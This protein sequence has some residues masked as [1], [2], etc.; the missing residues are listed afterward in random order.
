MHR[1]TRAI[2]QIVF[3]CSFTI[4]CVSPLK[5]NCQIAVFCF[6]RF[7]QKHHCAAASLPHTPFSFFRLTLLRVIRSRPLVTTN[8]CHYDLRFTA[9]SFSV[10]SFFPALR[11]VVASPSHSTARPITHTSPTLPSCLE[12]AM[13]ARWPRPA[14]L[15]P[16]KAV[17]CF[18][19]AAATHP[20]PRR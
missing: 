8:T 2:V 17:R 7:K 18:P 9:A 4:F 6:N 13:T 5:F 19:A 20:A 3:T 1:Q 11:S 15:P 12:L 14:P 16:A 10:F